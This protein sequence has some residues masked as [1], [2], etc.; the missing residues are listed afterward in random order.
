M[1]FD[2]I[3]DELAGLPTSAAVAARYVRVS[4]QSMPPTKL[5]LYTLDDSPAMLAAA[6]HA[7]FFVFGSEF[8]LPRR[9]LEE[10]G[11]TNLELGGPEIEP[12]GEDPGGRIVL[13]LSPGADDRLVV[14][15]RSIK[16]VRRAGDDDGGAAAGFRY[17]LSVNEAFDRVWDEI[18][19]T[20]G[21]DWLGFARLRAPYT[22]LH[23]LLPR[24]W[25][26][27]RGEED[28]ARAD[29]EAATAEAGR[30]RGMDV[31]AGAA[32]VFRPPR[33][34]S[35]ELWDE[36]TGALASA[37]VGVLVGRCY[38]C[39]SLLARTDKYPRC[40]QV[41]AQASVLWLRS[42]GVRLY[43]VGT[44][45][46]Y[47]ASLFGFRRTSR[48]EFVRLWRAH[49]SGRLEPAEAAVLGEGC[50]DLRGLLE[51]ER[52]AQRSQTNTATAGAAAGTTA[53]TTTT[54]V[55]SRT[56]SKSKSAV[57]VT[58]LPGG[59]SS[60]NLAAAFAPCGRVVKATMVDKARGDVSGGGGGVSGGGGGGGDGGGAEER[61]GVLL[62]EEEAGAQAALQLDGTTMA[63]GAA[64]PVR[65]RVSRAQT[66]AKQAKHAAKQA[67]KEAAARQL[68][69]DEPPRGGSG[70][71]RPRGAAAA[72]DDDEQPAA[73][74]RSIEPAPA[75]PPCKLHLEPCTGTSVVATITF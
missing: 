7:G 63:V 61:F 10:R 14:G 53:A 73:Q 59:L 32:V 17:R 62:F 2:E 67:Q 56:P 5:Q 27:T 20:H 12:Q 45:A 31:D 29:E 15:K 47:Y 4:A 41:R 54:S 1:F 38:S 43:D 68:Q 44:T 65:L 46:E 16:T 70:K 52:E 3:V 19:A 39:V 64:A 25:E 50:S 21:V 72:E 55:A 71:K 34:L 49:R 18:V 23:R 33:V 40:D 22:A 75:S 26:E 8:E 9:P 13:D 37:E 58:G 24:P 35:I 36:E 48:D 42:A 66:R 30:V 69:R 60:D 74:R 6:L 57:T 11:L 51:A 28:D